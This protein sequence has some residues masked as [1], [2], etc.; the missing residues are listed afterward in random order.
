MT[1]YE[2][3]SEKQTF[4]IGYELAAASKREQFIV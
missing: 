4:D 1:V 3:N 2:S